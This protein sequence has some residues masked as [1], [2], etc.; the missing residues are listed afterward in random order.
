MVNTNVIVWLDEK[1][2][3]EIRVWMGGWINSNLSV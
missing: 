3:N 1:V 2:I